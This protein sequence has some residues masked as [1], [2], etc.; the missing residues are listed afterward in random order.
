MGRLDLEL[1]N[2]NVTLDWRTKLDRVEVKVSQAGFGLGQG[3]LWQNKDHGK[4]VTFVG[5]LQCPGVDVLQVGQAELLVHEHHV[6][7]NGGTVSQVEGAL[8]RALRPELSG[9]VAFEVDGVDEDES[10]QIKV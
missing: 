5:H 2:V 4:P 6:R 8:P 7:L 10:E 9:P 1:G 3:L